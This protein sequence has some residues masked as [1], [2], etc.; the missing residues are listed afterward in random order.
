M[1]RP[2]LAALAL[3]LAVAGCQ[4][5][6]PQGGRL[7]PGDADAIRL[8]HV[9]AVNAVRLQAGAAPV[10]L[11]A[12]LNA[13]AE[14]HARD[15]SVQGRAWHFGSD[16]TSPRERA[17]RAGYR[18]E[19]VG[20]NLSEGADS[21]LTVLR[22]WLEFADTRAIILAPEARGVGLGW[23]QDATGKTWWVQVLGE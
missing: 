18:G 22:S 16:L 1:L 14:T 9:D 23:Y 20:E 3:L 8:R 10:Q 6:G 15:I 4:S 12:E 21:D 2:A 13:A 5:P 7:S 19:I 17:F 11:S